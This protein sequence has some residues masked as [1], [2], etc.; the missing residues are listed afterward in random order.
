MQHAQKR[1]YGDAPY[2]EVPRL[3][4][5]GAQYDPDNRSW[6]AGHEN[7]VNV[8][9]EVP[10]W[11]P[12][13]ETR[14]SI[15]A[16]RLPEFYLTGQ[17]FMLEGLSPQNG[18]RASQIAGVFV[19]D[20]RTFMMAA[21]ESGKFKPVVMVQHSSTVVQLAATSV[22]RLVVEEEKE[23]DALNQG[24]HG[25]NQLNQTSQANRVETYL[26]KELCIPTDSAASLRAV[27]E[28]GFGQS[29]I[30]ASCR[31]TSLGP[32]A[33]LSNA[34]RFLRALKFGLV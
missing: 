22:M 14:A 8:L 31:D 1:V 4:A 9:L 10:D 3:K 32:R 17:N 11:I 6:F 12:R 2:S 13:S 18:L 29:D 23:E 15:L 19:A 34:D 30:D 28:A 20:S 21:L 7:I 16:R 27:Q 25:L 24:R 33:G 5:A 26:R